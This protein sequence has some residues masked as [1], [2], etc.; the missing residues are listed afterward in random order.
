MSFLYE[1]LVRLKNSSYD[2][3]Y[4][5]AREAI[6]K[7]AYD[8]LLSA[9]QAPY[10]VLD[11]GLGWGDDLKAVRRRCAGMDIEY[12]GVETQENL[13]RE[14]NEAG[15]AT[16]SIDIEREPIP[17]EDE[18][19]DVVISNQV[20]EHTK[21]LF[22]IFSEISRVLKK[23][24][25]GIVGCPNLASWHNRVALMFGQQPSCMP[26]LSPHVRGITK[27]SFK[28]MIEHCGFFELIAYKGSCFYPF[29]PSIDKVVSRL[30]PTLCSNSTFMIRRTPKAGRYI[31]I[32]DS[33]VPGLGNTPYFRG[34]AVS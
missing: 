11:V 19:F 3:D 33:D 26:L 14:A 17:I 21:E 1:R 25:I 13:A 28:Q 20:I 23:G 18:Y 27:P 16:Y 15:I 32:L 30:L 34:Q 4:C 2:E 12:H 22:W 31:E 6:A 7:W 9:G 29:P 24:G 5:H 8:H 10:R